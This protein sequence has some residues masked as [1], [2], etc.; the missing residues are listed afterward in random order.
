MRALSMTSKSCD[1]SAPVVGACEC[2]MSGTVASI[3]RERDRARRPH[4]YGRTQDDA[5]SATI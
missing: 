4:L 1:C 3:S 5:L 2:D